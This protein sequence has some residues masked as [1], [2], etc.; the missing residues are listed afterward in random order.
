[1]HKISLLVV[2]GLTAAAW[3]GI[4]STL[5]AKSN[6]MVSPDRLRTSHMLLAAEPHV[7][8]TPGD[9]RVIGK[10]MASFTEMG[11]SPV[12]HDIWPLLCL[13]VSAELEVVS[14]RQISLSLKEAP[15]AGDKDSAH[16]ELT[17]G[18]NAYSGN[19]D[20]TAGVVYANYGREEDFARLAELGVS[21]K[22]RIV[23][24]RY[25]GNYRG[26]KAKF[27]E[28]AGAAG[29][30]IFSDPADVGFTKGA[31]YPEGTFFND[32]CIQR[33]SIVTLPY[34][35]DPL[36]PGKEATR[37]AERLDIEATRLPTIP[38]Q[39][40]S[41]GAAKEILALMTGA[42]APKEWQGGLPLTYRYEGGDELRV[43][44]KV[45]QRREIKQ[46]S[47]VLAEIRGTEFPDEKVIIGA[48]HD[49]WN[50]GASDPTCGTIVVL[51]AARVLAELAAQG[52]RPIRTVVFAAWGAEEFGIIGSSEWVEA[53]HD[54]L[55]RGGVAYLNLDMASMGPNFSAS[56]SPS[57]KRAIADC[58]ELVPS[59][60][61]G[62]KTIAAIGFGEIG[63]LGG[64][65][66][67]VGFLCHTGVA[68]AAFGSGGSTGS[69]YHS[70]YDTLP[71]YWKAVGADYASAAMV[72]RMTCAFAANL[73]Y[74]RPIPSDPSASFTL[75]RDTARARAAEP[76][77]DAG[78]AQI[79]GKMDEAR[80]R[81][82]AWV[83]GARD[84]G[85]RDPGAVAATNRAMLR[86]DRAWLADRS[87][88][89]RRSWFRNHLVST[90]ESSGYASWVLPAY[91][92]AVKHASG[93]E[94]DAAMDAYGRVIGISDAVMRG[95]EPTASER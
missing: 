57:L 3:A 87:G 73:A 8:G 85:S 64:G 15:V 33:G 22:D 71:W 82:E 39:P 49:A 29:L 13:P 43:R 62:D 50:H 28:A 75:A 91:T 77:A 2:A 52:Q 66:D 69:A 89:P 1:M 59:A 14:P 37:D 51:E 63:T 94:R 18:W 19:G 34:Q 44:L 9:E 5:V 42:E 38:V 74:Q 67:H 58:V 17:F 79:A 41:Y 27:A 35:G 72:T 11:L 54:A 81:T 25:G 60:S 32:C 6:Q 26:Y 92:A 40:V 48:H 53:N 46:T 12:R 95:S 45:E 20:V 55:L 83:A 76:N 90:D 86:L 68:S 65:S 21:V 61:A 36:T 78:W 70:A 84:A 16:P 30:I 93:A 56:A 4:D 23:L 10:I 24:A 7:A 31:V 47:N 80:T 88:L